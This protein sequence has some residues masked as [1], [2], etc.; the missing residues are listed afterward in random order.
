M[1]FQVNG[2]TADTGAILVALRA[3]DARARVDCD[4]AAGCIDVSAQMTSDQIVA[5]LRE[6]GY[7][8]SRASAPQR[9]HVSGGS[10]CC[11]SCG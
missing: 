3:H 4:L 7:E 9:I 5:T 6:A 11:G 8:A 2:L 10:D 1:L